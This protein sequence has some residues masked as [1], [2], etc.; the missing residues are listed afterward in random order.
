MFCHVLF[1]QINVN[2]HLTSHIPLIYIPLA[3]SSLPL[4]IVNV[5]AFNVD[6]SESSYY[7]FPFWL[8][9]AVVLN[10]AGVD[11]EYYY[12]R[13]LTVQKHLIFKISCLRTLL[14][15]GLSTFG[16]NFQPLP[17]KLLPNSRAKTWYVYSPW[18]CTLLPFTIQWE[19][20]CPML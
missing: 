14:R 12:A 19:I 16:M 15:I 1:V 11:S 18:E 9:C 7:A 4:V 3:P 2:T 8:F 5:T 6:F 13:R 17:S 10:D 20:C